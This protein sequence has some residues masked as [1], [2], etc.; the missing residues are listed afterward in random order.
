MTARSLASIEERIRRA[1]EDTRALRVRS[2]R[3]GSWGVVGF[4]SLFTSFSSWLAFQ[5]NGDPTVNRPPG[6]WLPTIFWSGVVSTVVL[7]L[8]VAL[9][10][11][12]SAEIHCG[13]ERITLRRQLA[14]LPKPQQAAVLASVGAGQCGDTQKLVRALRHDLGLP[15]PEVTPAEAPQGGNGELAA[16]EREG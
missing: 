14:A 7:L 15:S 11:L 4:V 3:R 6:E 9:Y 12:V 16:V 8:P 13:D 2:A 5:T 10:A 1:G